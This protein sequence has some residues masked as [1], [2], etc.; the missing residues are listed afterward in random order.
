M[1]I[2]TVEDLRR[3]LQWAI[4]LEHSTLPPYLCALY[5]LK[6]GHNREAAYSI[7]SVFI[8]EMLHMTL[9]ANVLNAVGGQPM[10]DR[11]EFVPRYPAYLPHSAD[12]FL[13]PLAPFAP[14]TI[15]TFMKIEKPE[16]ADAA[17]E[18]DRFH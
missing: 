11:P 12:A 18:T 9:A 16:Q 1:P 17:A 2:V 6:P 8:E 15:E 14:A 5:S 13:V 4:A 10:L 7:A 3:H